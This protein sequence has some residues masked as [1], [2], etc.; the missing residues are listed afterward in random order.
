MREPGIYSNITKTVVRDYGKGA[1]VLAV[2]TVTLHH[3][4]ILFFIQRD[5]KDLISPY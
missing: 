5:Q 2:T 3:L 4:H 1:Y